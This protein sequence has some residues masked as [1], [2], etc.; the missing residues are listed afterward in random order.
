MGTQQVYWRVIKRQQVG[1]EPLMC[2][3][4]V[5]LLRGA[6][7]KM[8]TREPLHKRVKIKDS[9]VMEYLLYDGPGPTILFLHG[10]GFSPWLWHPIARR[11]NDE[12]RIIAPFSCDHRDAEPEEGGLKWKLLAEDLVAFC[13][14]LNLSNLYIV[15]HSMGATVATITASLDETLARK[16][17]LMEPIYLP[18][19]LYSMKMSVDQHPLASKSIKR[20]NAWR[21]RQEARE[22]LL[23]RALYNSWDAEMLDLFLC[24]GMVE[25]EAG[26]IRLACSPRREAAVFMGGVHYNP[27]PLLREIQCPVLVME[28]ECSENRPL[29]DLKRAAS[30]I[31]QGEY[32]L[33]TGIGHTIPMEIPEKITALTRHFCHS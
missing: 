22:Y 26:G 5:A 18:E 30:L 25:N 12:F 3:G 10:T 9:L 32:R 2:W 13:H 29:I 19:A 31:P 24:H 7:R 17:L 21:D 8:V 4:E 27:W 1:C 33:I 6:W 28:G 11:L 16:M 23:A 15:A 20:R 14:Q